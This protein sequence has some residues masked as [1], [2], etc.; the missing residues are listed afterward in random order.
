MKKAVV[1]LSI[2]KEKTLEE[3]QEEFARKLLMSL[4]QGRHLVLLC[5]NSNPPITSKFAHADLF[6]MSAEG[7][8]DAA[9]LKACLGV[10]PKLDETFLAGLIKHM[11]ESGLNADPT[12]S[13]S[14]GHADFRVVL[15]TKFEPA[16]YRGFL[17]GE[18]PFD[19]LQPIRVTTST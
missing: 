11:G 18:L 1:E 8:L 10:G 3:L 2:K 5:S 7:L 17:E 14:F 16:D 12:Y 6:P 9:K 4:K 13:V 15:V 19:K